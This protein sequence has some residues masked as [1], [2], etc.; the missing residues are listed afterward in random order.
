LPPG[1][2]VCIYC[3]YNRETGTTLQRVHEKVDKQ[4]QR[5]LGLPVRLEVF[6]PVQGLALAATLVVL[7][8]EGNWV[9][10]AM[11]W[12]IG[13][14]LLAFLLGTYPHLKRPFCGGS[15]SSNRTSLTWP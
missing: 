10:L 6:L 8:A 7:I 1:A 5:G 14:S 15:S 12:M 9:G 13:A 2:I 11:S 4:W 3:G